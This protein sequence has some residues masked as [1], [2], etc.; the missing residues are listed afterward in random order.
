M[1]K[2]HERVVDQ[3]RRRLRHED[4]HLKFNPGDTK[5]RRLWDEYMRAYE[6]MLSL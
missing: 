6:L 1:H 4:K 3:L 2:L 5:E